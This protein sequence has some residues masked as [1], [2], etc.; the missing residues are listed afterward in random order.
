MSTT[1]KLPPTA[2]D[3]L[4]YQRLVVD[5]ASTRT[6]ADEVHVSQ[7]RVRQIA[8]RVTHWLVETLPTADADLSDDAK[9]CLGQH[10]AADRLERLY[11]TTNRAFQET[12]QVKF[13]NLS[14]RA[15][16]ALS[17]LP[18]I[19]GTLEALAADAILGPLPD[20]TSSL[21]TTSNSPSQNPQSQIPNP[22]S[23]IP[24][25]RACSPPL[26]NPP[27]T[28][29]TQSPTPAATPTAP[30]PCDILPP[31]TR[32]ARSAFLASAHLSEKTDDAPILELKITPEKLG[33]ST[34]TN[35]NLSRKD[36]RRLRRLAMTKK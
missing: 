23:E 11:F 32:S 22:K 12:A 20:D 36:R 28:A 17:K 21:Y 19:P 33:L 24:P 4:V 8:L 16:T 26:K 1:P 10:I 18:A 31:A 35:K 5:A 2:R 7:T 30:K 34:T 9:L 25:L 13:A 6:V 29:K 3:F 15:L 14:I 27:A